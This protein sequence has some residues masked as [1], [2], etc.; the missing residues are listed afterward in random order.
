M[1]TNNFMENLA[2]ELQDKENLSESS[3]IEYVKK[4][5]A[6]NNKKPFKNLAFL[7]NKTRVH[8]IMNAYSPSTKKSMLGAIT[9]IIKMKNNKTYK[10]LYDYYWDLLKDKDADYN[11]KPKN[12]KTKKQKQ[13]WVTWEF[14]EEKLKD[15]KQQAETLS[16][17]KSLNKKEYDTI[18]SFLI[19]SLYTD[20]PPRRNQDY[21]N[22][23]LVKEY[24]TKLDEERNYYDM[25]NKEFIFNRYKT[26]KSYGQQVISLKD[27]KQLLETIELYLKYHPLN[28]GRKSKSWAAPF[29]VY[30]D[31]SPFTQVNAITRVL[32]R[33]FGKNIGSSMLRHIYLTNKYGEQMDD[34][35]DDASKMAHSHGTQGEY[36]IKGNGTCQTQEENK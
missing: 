33:I 2:N 21:S 6:I 8:E 26:W 17:K 9:T 14:I 16:K 15:L 34:M 28:K 25:K 1:I 12:E 31:G 11:N 35:I 4:L 36:V 19:L 23:Y 24:N 18:L 5:Y 29:L 20:L 3:A 22:M 30:F 27:E 32:N 7:K 10:S 13:N